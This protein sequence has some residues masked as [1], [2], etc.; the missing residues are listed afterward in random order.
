MR[1][2]PRALRERVVRAIERGATIAATAE[3]FEVGTATVSRWIRLAREQGH[4]DPA[5]T[6]LRGSVLDEHAA[7]LDRLREREPALSCQAVVDRLA[8]EKG[9]RVHE[10]TL[11]YWLRGRGITHKKSRRSPRSA[12]AGTSRLPAGCGVAINARSNP[13]GWCSSTRPARRR[14]WPRATDGGREGSG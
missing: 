2:Y 10:T 14:T 8:G 3:R 4:L 7:W 12:S 6:P 13:S 9:L 11:W 1:G 5:P